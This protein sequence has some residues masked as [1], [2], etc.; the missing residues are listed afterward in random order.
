MNG[1]EPDLGCPRGLS[2]P[3]G[4]G[5]DIGPRGVAT[6]HA[7]EGQS[8]AGTR[9]LW[10][11]GMT[12]SSRFTCRILS[13]DEDREFSSLEAKGTSVDGVELREKVPEAVECHSRESLHR[14]MAPPKTKVP[15]LRRKVGHPSPKDA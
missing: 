1:R 9:R 7:E 8:K 2:L 14:V 10:L 3:F 12:G 4:R 11:R 13:D 15:F 6:L 5:L